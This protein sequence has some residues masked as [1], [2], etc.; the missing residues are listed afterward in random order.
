METRRETLT[1]CVYL[2]LTRDEAV[3]RISQRRVCPVDGE[4]Y[5]LAAH[6][7]AV[8]GKCDRCG[9]ALIQRTDD[10]E[11]TVVKRWKLFEEQTFPVVDYYRQ[12][13]ILLSLDASRSAADLQADVLAALVPAN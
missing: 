5:H 9:G 12:Q 10:E 4:V 1:M 3:R 13:G 6:P 2:N 7:P 8:S 11:E